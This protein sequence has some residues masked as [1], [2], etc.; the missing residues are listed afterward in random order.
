VDFVGRCSSYVKFWASL[1][2]HVRE[3][4]PSG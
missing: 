2:D 1:G 3:P 4:T